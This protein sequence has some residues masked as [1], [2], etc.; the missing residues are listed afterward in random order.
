[1]TSEPVNN[2]TVGYLRVICNFSRNRPKL[3]VCDRCKATFQL[4]QFAPGCW[5]CLRCIW[6]EREALLAVCRHTAVT[7][8]SDL[9]Q[10]PKPENV[11][12]RRLRCRVHQVIG[13]VTKESV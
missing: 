6:N 13:T 2:E 8:D 4:Y 3:P 10:N 5:R 1:M 7:L 12:F 9:L 11:L